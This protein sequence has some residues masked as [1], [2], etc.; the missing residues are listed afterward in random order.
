MA[1]ALPLGWEEHVSRSTGEP[2]YFNSSTG[3][4]TYDFPNEQPSHD[5]EDYT[6]RAL[7]YEPPPAFDEGV[8]DADDFPPPPPSEPEEP[9]TDGIFAADQQT[10]SRD[11]REAQKA[12][13][14]ERAASSR[15][16]KS[17]LMAVDDTEYPRGLATDDRPT[18][19]GIFETPGRTASAAQLDEPV[20][21]LE[22]E[23]FANPWQTQISSSTGEP[24]W[25][26]ALTGASTYELPPELDVLPELSDISTVDGDELDA[27]TD[28]VP[29]AGVCAQFPCTRAV[30]DGV[31][32][33]ALTDVDHVARTQDAMHFRGSTLWSGE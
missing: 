5:L 24:Y 28:A 33:R 15:C 23:T 21:H 4:T 20:E 10:R 32:C 1:G 29:V 12:R 14:K 25:Y 11:V 31:N 17:A 9:P 26:N 19:A 3:E 27:S 30:A 2:Y 8:E 16:I 18:G 13:N 22:P 6:A 7:D